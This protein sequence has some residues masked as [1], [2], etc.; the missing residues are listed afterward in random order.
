ME[1][2]TCG[3]CVCVVSKASVCDHVSLLQLDAFYCLVVHLGFA[4]VFKPK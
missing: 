1:T 3:V 2:S 4:V